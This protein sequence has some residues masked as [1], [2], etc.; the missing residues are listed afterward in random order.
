M[1]AQIFVLAGVNGAGK[2]SIG[3]AALQSKGVDCFNPDLVAR[4]LQ[5]ANPALSIEQANGQAWTL[6]RRGLERALAE[7][8]NFACET[9]LGGKTLP[10]ILLKGARAG[11]AVHL[12][13]AGLESPELHMARVRN[14]VS[15]GCHDIPEIKILERYTASI[16][17]LVRLLPHLSSLRVY[18]NSI[19]RD[20]KLGQA[21]EPRLLLHMQDGA[22]LSHE[23]L[24][25]IPVWAR[26]V[27]AAALRPAR[28]RH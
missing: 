22:V 26:P 11:A 5:D 2:S 10:D 23:P 25:R 13:F 17:N 7:S 18:D 16:L 3:G 21:P 9:T 24:D 1:V 14:R 4:A 27:L 12:W 8:G 15:A 6:G 19:E 20:P 28:V